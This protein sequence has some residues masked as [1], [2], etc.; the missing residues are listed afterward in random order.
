MNKPALPRSHDRLFQKHT[1]LLQSQITC[2]SFTKLKEMN[3]SDRSGSKSSSFVAET[4]NRAESDDVLV[5][6]KS[7]MILEKERE[8][9]TRE[10]N[11]P[12]KTEKTKETHRI[13]PRTHSILM[14]KHPG[15]G[16]RYENK[17][18]PA[19]GKLSLS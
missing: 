2:E 15:L 1:R 10:K 9:K 5:G 6:F 17:T 8:K 4:P 7:S 11:V 12:K 14:M 16:T 18:G 3:S 19:N 13:G